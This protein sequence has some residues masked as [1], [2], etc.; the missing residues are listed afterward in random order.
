M[1]FLRKIVTKT[2]LQHLVFWVLSLYAVGSFFSISN[3]VKVIDYVYALFFH[4]PL[5]ALVYLNLKV[6]IPFSFGKNKPMLFFVWSICNMGLAYGLHAMVFEIVLPVL[7]VTYYIVS[8]TDTSVLLS[9]FF[10]Y[11]VLSTLIKLSRS[12]YHLQQLIQEKLELELNSLK[13]QVNPHF[14]FNSLNSIYSLALKKADDTPK[15]V[16]ELSNLM[17]YMLYEVS[18]AQVPLEK[19]VKIM[20]HYVD[21]QKLR[22]G[23]EADI[24]FQVK[25]AFEK[26]MIAPLL[27]FPLIENSFK[28]GV[29]GDVERPYV[30]IRLFLEDSILRFETANNKGKTDD[31][32]GGKFGGIGLGNVKK[33]L[34]LIYPGVASIQVVDEEAHFGVRIKIR[35]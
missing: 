27:F 5:V 23:R 10:V 9:I 26:Q 30:H 16:L 21:L 22:V 3:E 1:V 34:Q 2:W 28:H 17:R 24:I 6:S 29:G 35:L 18:D 19:E 31:I 14:L 33:R 11:L 13:T 12:W 15:A 4:I 7:P 8:F 25:G 20:Q 32:E